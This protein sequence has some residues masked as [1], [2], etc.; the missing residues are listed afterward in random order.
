MK[1]NH[2]SQQ[3]AETIMIALDQVSQ[4]ID[5]MNMIVSRLKKRMSDSLDTRPAVERRN[6]SATDSHSAPNKT[7]DTFENGSIH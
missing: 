7:P 2:I 3:D 4:T 6:T 1:E 5:V